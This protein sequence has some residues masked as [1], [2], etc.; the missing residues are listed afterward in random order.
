MWCLASTSLHIRTAQI[1]WLYVQNVHFQNRIYCMVSGL[2]PPLYGFR[3]R[4]STIFVL[5]CISEFLGNHRTHSAILSQRI[6]V[7]LLSYTQ[8][9]W[10]RN[11]LSRWLLL[12]PSSI[13]EVLTQVKYYF[14]MDKLDTLRTKHTSTKKWFKKWKLFIFTF[15]D[16]EEIRQLMTPFFNTNW[17]L[18]S[19][20]AGGLGRLRI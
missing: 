12:S 11:L 9:F 18:S 16:D 6:P 19:D 4:W 3:K 15:L 20:L 1:A 5:K 14:T 10:H 8:Y 2:V 17:Y 13:S 7:P